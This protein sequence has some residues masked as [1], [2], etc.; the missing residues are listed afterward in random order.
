VPKTIRIP[1]KDAHH[2]RSTIEAAGL[3]Y[4]LLV[5]VSGSHRGMNMVR[6]DSPK[7]LDAAERL[8]R[9]SHSALYVTEFHDFG[10]NDG[11]FRKYRI[12]VVGDDIFLRH[13]VTADD[14]LIYGERRA[15]NTREEE[16]AAFERFG[17][18][19][20][21]RLRPMFQEI[22]R[23]LDLDFF[24]ADCSIDSSGK[25]LLF[26]ANACMGILRRFNQRDAT[27]AARKAKEGA[28]DAI[29]AAVEGRLAA[30]ATWRHSA[31][32]AARDTAAV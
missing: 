18:D 7:E 29:Q 2:L 16:I 1:G 4:P 21:M 19:T 30:P 23:R 11:R 32:L 8:K 25:V 24:G 14:W 12:V 5:R 27:N 20:G 28:I 17:R 13:M 26:E 15:P 22:A 6:V 31:R 3:R 10:N 9:S